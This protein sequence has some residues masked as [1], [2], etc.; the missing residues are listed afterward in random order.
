MK[1]LFS[2]FLTGVFVFGCARV[3][4]EAPKESIKVDISMRLD[5]YQ[6]VQQDIDAIENIVSGGEKKAES[7]GNSQSWRGNFLKLAYAQEPLSPE[8]EE[9]ALRRKGR[10]PQLAAWQEKGVLGEN[11][12]GLIEI[13]QSPVMDSTPQELVKTE[14]KDRMIIYQSLAQKNKT[15]VEE[16]Q[17][18]YVSY[19]HQNAPVGTPIEVLNE[20]AGKY[21]W[22][23]K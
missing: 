3:R 16:I 22:K 8:I 6:H 5:I 20:P 2:L 21:E 13:R 10:L 12:F 11:R 9:A 1:L 4:L 18:L 19:L 14:N 7:K 15:T 23:I 17:K